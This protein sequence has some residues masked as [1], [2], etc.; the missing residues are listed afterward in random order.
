M[1]GI[2][3]DRTK[4]RL[5]V[6]A[7]VL[8]VGASCAKAA[9]EVSTGAPD[10]TGSEATS[11][12]E[13]TSAPSSTV[14]ADPEASD[15]AARLAAASEAATAAGSGRFEMRM[16]MLGLGDLD[17]VTLTLDGVFAADGRAQMSMD[18]SD[19][20]DAIAAAGAEGGE[21]IGGE[22]FTGLFD[23]PIE[24]VVDGE[25]TYLKMGFI[26]SLLGARTDWVSTPTA[27]GSTADLTGVGVPGASDPTAFLDLL[28]RLDADVD[29]LG[30][31]EVNGVQA[32][33]YR[34]AIDFAALADVMGDAGGEGFDEVPPGLFAAPI[35][36]EVWISEDGLPVRLAIL[37]EGEVMA[38]MAPAGEGQGV[39]LAGASMELVIDFFDLG[40]PVEIEVP[41]PADVT[42]IDESSFGALG[43]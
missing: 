21:G 35:P 36:F 11:R 17:D 4:M 32:E 31:D 41:D 28:D 14:A 37:L 10:S 7:A 3:L 25:T 24:V 15:A 30:I 26:A 22:L 1:G 5:I 20:M 42:P 43:E 23:E 39:D 16:T 6:A 18:L 12:T 9:D 29:A 27:E 40:E 2:M 34:V 8:L 38:G 13:V 33:G 19:M